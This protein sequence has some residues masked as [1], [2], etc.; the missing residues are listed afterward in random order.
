MRDF[1]GVEKKFMILL[2]KQRKVSIFPE[3]LQVFSRI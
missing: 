3:V 2:E 1:S